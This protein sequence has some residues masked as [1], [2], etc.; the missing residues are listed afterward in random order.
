MLVEDRLRQGLEANATS[1]AP[2]TEW[3]LAQV[4]RR[5]RRRRTTTVVASVGTAAAAVVAAA[6]LQL[7]GASL[8][9]PGPD[10]GPAGPGQVQPS[11]GTPTAIP[12]AGGFVHEV[13]EKQG[14]A[15][16]VPRRTVERLAGKDGV[17]P[18]GFKLQQRTFTIWTNDDR[19]SP[20]AH[21]Y[22]TYEFRPGGR[23]VLTSVSDR[24]PGCTT[25][26]SWRWAGRDVVISSVDRDT[27][28]ALARWLWKGRWYYQA[29][30]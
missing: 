24:C 22:G 13:T 23:L 20:T 27:G 11:S 19:Y 2:A 25:T 16:G 14:L 17:L 18:L 15:L 29:P 21:D 5:Q 1:F 8:P 12:E 10:R 26:L 4:R 7:A 28:G 6:V 30:G 3:R 9:V